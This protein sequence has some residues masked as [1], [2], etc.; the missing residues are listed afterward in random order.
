MSKV[1]DF[2]KKLKVLRVCNDDTLRTLAN[3]LNVSTAYLSYLELGKRSIPK[4]M[5]AKIAELYDLSDTET[6]ELMEA[7]D[8][9]LPTYSVNASNLSANQRNLLAELA[10]RINYLDNDDIEDI[11]NIL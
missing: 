11:L 10:K 8:K 3:K 5:V 2:G 6:F 9:S 1:T 4:K 7:R